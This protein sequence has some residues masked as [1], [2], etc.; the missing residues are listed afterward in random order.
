M[1]EHTLPP[2]LIEVFSEARLRR[3]MRPGE[4]Y[5]QAFARYQENIRLS[6]SLLPALHY[7]EVILRNRLDTAI[8]QVYGKDWL[9][10]VPAALPMEAYNREK[11]SAAHAAFRFEKRRAPTHNDLVATMTFGFWCALFHKRYDPALWHRGHFFPTVFPNWPREQRKRGVIQPK[12]YIIK[13]LRNRIAHHEPIGDW[14]PGATIGHRLCL[15]LIGAMTP[16]ALERLREVD[17]FAGA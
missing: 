14:K 5:T 7:L 11:I 8:R 3:Y 10:R 15:E 17:R 16:E 13:D 4:D 12:L 2:A 9:L 1:T 6:E